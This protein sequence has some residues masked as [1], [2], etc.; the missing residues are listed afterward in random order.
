MNSAL[1]L[2]RLVYSTD[3]NDNNADLKILARILDPTGAAA[4]STLPNFT[5]EN[6]QVTTT[7]E[8]SSFALIGLGLVLGSAA[9]RQR[10]KDRR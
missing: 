8:P 5:A 10:L 2:R 4:I 7:P 9:L 3:L 1:N 6:F